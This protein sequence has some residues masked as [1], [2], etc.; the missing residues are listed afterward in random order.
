MLEYAG[1]LSGG[2][3]NWADSGVSNHGGAQAAKQCWH[4]HHFPSATTANQTVGSYTTGGC[5]SFAGQLRKQSTVLQET[6]L[7]AKLRSLPTFIVIGSEDGLKESRSANC[8]PRF[9]ADSFAWIRV[10]N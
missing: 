2:A 4:S 7:K 9:S 8:S 3:A 5:K 10:S 1:Q 6:P